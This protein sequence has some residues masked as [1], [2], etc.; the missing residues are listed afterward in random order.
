ISF[1]ARHDRH[2][3]VVDH[4]AKPAI[5]G[6]AADFSRWQRS[7]AE[8]A[9]MPHVAVKA[10]GLA[11][12]AQTAPG[13]AP[14]LDGIRRHLDAA[15]ELFGE[16]RLVFGSDWPVCR[17]ATTYTDW[18]TEVDGWAHSQDAGLHRKLFGANAADV[19]A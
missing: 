18:L 6:D 3:L 7:M 17:L 2:R 4:L 13:A 9:A 19:Y 15:L 8:L 12:E 14:D 11:T 1:C 16:D 10:S 5:T